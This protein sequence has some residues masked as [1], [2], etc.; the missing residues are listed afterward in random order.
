MIKNYNYSGYFLTDCNANTDNINNANV[1]NQTNSTESH[2]DINTLKFIKENS[3]SNITHKLV[4]DGA[5]KEFK[6]QG[7]F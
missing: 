7:F 6:I 2:I 1:R 5:S 4:A 3:T